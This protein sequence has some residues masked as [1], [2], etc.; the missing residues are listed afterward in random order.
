MQD[1]LV[2]GKVFDQAAFAERKI[3]LNCIA[4]MLGRLG[5][6]AWQVQQDHPV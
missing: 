2:I 6:R 3:E 5:G 1:V 4:M